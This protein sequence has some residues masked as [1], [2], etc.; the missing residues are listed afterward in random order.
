MRELSTSRVEQLLRWWWPV[1]HGKAAGAVCTRPQIAIGHLFSRP[2]P[3]GRGDQPGSHLITNERSC[4]HPCTHLAAAHVVTWSTQ[5]QKIEF[6]GIVLY[7]EE[8]FIYSKRIYNE[9][10]KFDQNWIRFWIWSHSTNVLWITKFG[11][12]YDYDNMYFLTDRKIFF[13]DVFLV[14]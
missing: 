9:R 1:R 4:E 6:S 2:R 14:V 7:L 11:Y 3:I 10:S 13:S 5:C 8:F 12:N